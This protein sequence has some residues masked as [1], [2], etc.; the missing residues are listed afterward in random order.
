MQKDYNVRPYMSLF[1][2]CKSMLTAKFRFKVCILLKKQKN[3]WPLF[4][5][6]RK[7]D[8]KHFLIFLQYFALFMLCYGT[9]FRVILMSNLPRFLQHCSC[10]Y[11]TDSRWWS[12]LRR[13]K[14]AL[15]KSSFG[16]GR[17][18]QQKRSNSQRIAILSSSSMCNDRS[19]D[20]PMPKVREN[21][22]E[23]HLLTL[24]NTYKMGLEFDKAHIILFHLL[25]T[26]FLKM[27]VEGVESWIP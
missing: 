19:P 11:V 22:L 6:Y 3:S 10:L 25:S 15:V 17:R 21:S 20:S 13:H 8:V 2:L 4:G 23:S 26:L 16:V 18:Q 27:V 9:F 7:L 24:L 14:C 12:F 1:N 5:G